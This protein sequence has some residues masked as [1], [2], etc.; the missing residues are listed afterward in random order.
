MTQLFSNLVQSKLPHL[1]SVSLI[2]TLT[3]VGLTT[4]PVSALTWTLNPNSQV[5]TSP[6]TTPL[7]GSFTIDDESLINP[8]ITASNI[9]LGSL[10]FIADDVIN[11][12]VAGGITAIDWLDQDNNVLSLVFNSPLTSLGGN[13]ILNSTVSNFTDSNADEFVVVGSVSTS[14]PEPSTLLG[15]IL[16]VVAL[17]TGKKL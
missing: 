9:N 8:S 11:I 13:V 14:V 4:T 12:D 16:T 3:T 15:L 5:Q 1:V 10:V 7:T 6:T 17:S 2:S